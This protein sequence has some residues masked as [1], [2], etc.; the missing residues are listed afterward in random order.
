[1]TSE[2]GRR[3]L[4]KRAAVAGV[5]AFAA[6]EL[7]ALGSDI[8]GKLRLLAGTVWRKVDHIG[9]SYSHALPG[10]AACRGVVG[11]WPAGSG[12][13]ARRAS[14]V[15]QRP[16]RRQIIRR[17]VIIEVAGAVAAVAAALQYAESDRAREY[18]AA[19]VSAFA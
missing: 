16:A 7:A 5:Y 10:R 9:G 17:H 8:R 6:D 11:E 3:D 2:T 4:I 13:G 1:M 15:Q 12:R 19:T 14:I 18:R